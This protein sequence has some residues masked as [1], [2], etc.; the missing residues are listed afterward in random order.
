MLVTPYEYPSAVKGA[1]RWQLGF[2]AQEW[3][4]LSGLY[5]AVAL[6]HVAGWG[7]YC[8]HSARHPSL[9]GLGLVAYMFGVRHAFD[10]DH[11]AAVDDT[12]RFLLQRNRRQ[13][14]IGFYFSLGHATVVFV[15]AAG[16][17]LA[18]ALVR[19]ELPQWQAAGSVI[20]AGVSG[21]FLCFIGIL[22]LLV[23]L[24]LVK[25]WRGARLP[26]T[27]MRT[28]MMCWHAAACSIAYW[29]SAFSS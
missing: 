22:N 16:I 8:F 14:G 7:L 12:V 24:D 2:T 4:R 19:R 23:L 10:A 1:P 20:G 11:I 18:A 9:L 3:V 13:L 28:T 21:A 15:L 25:S 26:V 5:A 29:D 17:A 27:P 6:L